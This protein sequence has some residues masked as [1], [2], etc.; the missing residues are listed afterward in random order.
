MS[1]KKVAAINIGSSSVNIAFRDEKDNIKKL[2]E[3]DIDSGHSEKVIELLKKSGLPSDV[4]L[5]HR[6][7]HGGKRTSPVR[8][9]ESVIESL[10]KW[11]GVDGIHMIP[12][13]SVIQS[14]QDSFEQYAYFDTSFHQTIPKERTMYAIPEKYR[15]AGVRKYGFHGLSVKKASREKGEGIVLHLGSGCSLTAVQDGVSMDT[16]M[17]FTPLA[18]TA[19]RTRPGSIGPGVVAWLSKHED[20]IFNFLNTECGW[21]AVAETKGFKDIVSS[22]K[23]KDVEA[24]RLFVESVSREL[25][26]LLRTVPDISY[27]VF[28]GGVGEHN[29]ELR[30]RIC[31][32]IGPYKVGIDPDKNSNNSSKIST[33][34]SDLDVYVFV[35]REEELMIEEVE[36]CISK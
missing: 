35:A 33:E 20:D 15:D 14:L 23:T 10:K 1:K 29:A 26:M 27:L 6:V 2:S 7:V 5:C 36:K 25:H 4:V 21:E 24:T 3:T 9:T 8:L 30:H 22:G 12:E 28:T 31:L 32:S 19:M 16:T 34:D 18:G 17:G 11:E 13:L